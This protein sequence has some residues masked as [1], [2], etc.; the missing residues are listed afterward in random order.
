MLVNRCPPTGTVA[1][2][3]MAYCGGQWWS[4]D[5]PSTIAGK[6]T[7]KKN[8]GLGGAFFWELSGDTANGELINALYT[9]R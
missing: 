8:Q 1:G 4:Y 2:T 9:N 3:A 5:T 7:Y 6:M